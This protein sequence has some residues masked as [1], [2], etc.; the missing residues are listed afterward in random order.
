M[1][2]RIRRLFSAA[3]SLSTTFW[4]QAAEPARIQPDIVYGHKDGLALTF[5]VVRPEN[6]NGAG[7]LWL[8]NSTASR[9]TQTLQNCP[10]SLG[11]I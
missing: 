7:V 11:L 6:P 8:Q 10:Q 2:R 4:A 3:F 9:I 5:D 1:N